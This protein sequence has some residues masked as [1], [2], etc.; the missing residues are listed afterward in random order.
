MFKKMRC[1]KQELDHPTTMELLDSAEYGVLATCGENN[2]PYALPLNYACHGGAIY[3]HC[4]TTGHK[5]DN[6]AHN[7]KVSFCLVPEAELL[8]KEFTS[9]FKSVVVFGRA[10]IVEGDEKVAGLRALIQKFSPNFQEEGEKLIEKSGP[11]TTVVK[12]TIDAV[13]GKE[14]D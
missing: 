7:D 8:P 3:F 9:R 11:R 12:I 4:A 10:S 2:Y 14:G 5:L 6:I 1:K 13:T